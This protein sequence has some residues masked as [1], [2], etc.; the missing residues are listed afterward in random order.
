MRTNRE[1]TNKYYRRKLAEFKWFVRKENRFSNPLF[2]PRH[3]ILFC[4]RGRRVMLVHLAYCL[5]EYRVIT[6]LLFQ[7]GPLCF[8]FVK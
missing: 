5:G 8:E 2:N 6:T 7:R 4:G 3:C 1:I